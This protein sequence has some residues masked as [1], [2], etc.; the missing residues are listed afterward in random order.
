M[1]LRLAPGPEPESPGSEPSSDATHGETR[2][3]SLCPAAPPL[4]APTPGAEPQTEHPPA[5]A[6]PI[7]ATD[8][9]TSPQPTPA[10]QPR[11]E[12]T[13]AVAS[14]R[15]FALTD[16]GFAERILSQHGVDLR[17]CEPLGGW[18][19]WNDAQWRRDDSGQIWL[20]AHK[21][22][23]GILME[24]AEVDGDDEAAKARVK[25]ITAFAL[26]CE[27]RSRL[28]SGVKLAARLGSSFGVVARPTD[29]DVDPW[30]LNTPS[31]IVDLRTGRLQASSRDAMCSRITG[32]PYIPG[33]RSDL[34]D[35]F[36][37]RGLPD[38]EVRAFVQRAAGSSITGNPTEEKLYFAHGVAATGK[39]TFVRAVLSALGDYGMTADFE[40]FLSR[41]FTS[42]SPRNDIARLAGARFVV[43]IEVDEGKRL[44]EGVI[45]AL[46][47]RDRVPAR[48]LYREAFEFAPSFTLWL[49]ANHRPHVSADDGAMWRRIVQVPFGVQIPEGERDPSLKDR[50]CDPRGGGTAILSWLIEGCLA[51]QREGLRI[52]EAVR[53]ATQEYRDEVDDVAHFIDECCDV[54]PTFDA[55]AGD[56]HETY[57][58][59]SAVSGGVSMDQKRFK[60]ALTAKRFHHQRISSGVVWKG[61]RIRA[62]PM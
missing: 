6:Q 39:S 47:G 51:W 43:S 12:K 20:R 7:D 16:A 48:F 23:R 31:G 35:K 8:S 17:Y 13:A 41:E 11:D 34:W 37:A 29:F 25:A 1:P 61:L 32:A 38:P 18:F 3:R 57:R 24:A 50:L 49:A 27:S 60:A 10:G 62:Q 5:D 53:R 21:T 22:A 55:P 44:A 42:G 54:G 26:T 52:P 58:K 14:R 59:W 30:L 36:L 2:E 15:R 9:S 4:T 40:T 28:E 45:K 56:L 33:A 19:V 46:T